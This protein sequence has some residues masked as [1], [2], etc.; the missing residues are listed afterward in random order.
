MRLNFIKETGTEVKTAGIFAAAALV[1]SLLTGFLSG[2]GA[3]TVILR[4]FL[5]LVIFACL[6]F[7]AAWILKKFV[8]E[9]VSGFSGS[10][11]DAD[12]VKES[13]QDVSDHENDS[14]SEQAEIQT[15]DSGSEA[16]DSGF[17]ELSGKDFPS[18]SSTGT[19][20]DD[21]VENQNVSM[22]KHIVSNDENSF[23]YDPETMAMAVRTMIKKD[24]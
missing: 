19:S 20:S 8:P 7:G 1:I 23:G 3:G 6:G 9:L 21:G 10:S 24:E 15:E 12:E 16:G 5:A 18:V 17:S 22:G 13:A 2:I 14:G 4:S 11:D